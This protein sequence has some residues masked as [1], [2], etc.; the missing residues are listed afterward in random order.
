MLAQ[1]N[2]ILPAQ[3]GEKGGRGEVAGWVGQAEEDAGPPGRGGLLG[4]RNRAT[5]QVE[6]GDLGPAGGRRAS[7]TG[8]EIPRPSWVRVC[9]P[10]RLY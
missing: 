5:T 10:S 9:Q 6:R 3:P 4:H 1:P 8:V 7:P 2:K